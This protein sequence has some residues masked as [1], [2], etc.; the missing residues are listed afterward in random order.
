M[1]TACL[2]MSGYRTSPAR[3]TIAPKTTAAA[4][5]GF[6]AAQIAS[7]R[8]GRKPQ[9]GRALRQLRES[10]ALSEIQELNSI[11]YSLF[12]IQIVFMF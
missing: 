2:V 1:D 8:D 7:V 5:D 12:Q 3:T 6:I 9:R 4:R 11:Q 10:S